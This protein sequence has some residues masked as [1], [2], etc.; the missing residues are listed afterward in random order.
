MFSL[1]A[2]GSLSAEQMWGR[3]TVEL[4]GRPSGSRRPVLGEALSLWEMGVPCRSSSSASF[5]GQASLLWQGKG[6]VDSGATGV[7]ASP[8]T[9]V[10]GHGRALRGW[11]S[12][13][14]LRWSLSPFFLLTPEMLLKASVPPSVFCSKKGTSSWSTR[15]PT[16]WLPAA[17]D[18]RSSLLLWPFSKP[19][20]SLLLP[21]SV[22]S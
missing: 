10:N 2:S 14:L 3:W 13:E 1:L 22:R 21:S 18:T 9:S 7:E 20:L 6:L 17:W 12:A 11:D 8:P 15:K 19:G 16:R 5:T 4:E